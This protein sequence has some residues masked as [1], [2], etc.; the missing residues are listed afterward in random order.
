MTAYTT[1]MPAGFAGNIS[2]D[3]NLLVDPVIIDSGTPPTAYGSVVKLVSS[4]A[5]PVASGDAGSVAY[6]W[7]ARPYPVQST[8]NSL[9]VAAPPASGIINVMRRGFMT[10]NLV[11]GTAAKGGQ[12]YVV[13]TAGGSVAVGDIVT[14]SSPAGGGTGVVVTGATFMGAADANGIVEIFQAR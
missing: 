11:L 10:V 2:R 1:R 9:G 6:G 4:K 3:D 8:T 5:Q 14:S 7:S 13:T 12:V